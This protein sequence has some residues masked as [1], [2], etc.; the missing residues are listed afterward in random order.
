MTKHAPLIDF[1][2]IMERAVPEPN[3]GC[4]LWMRALTSAGYATIGWK[5]YPHRMIYRLFKGEIPSGLDL[6]H[7]CR[8]RSCVNPDHLEP[9]TRRENLRRGINW[10]REKTHC[11]QGHPYDKENTL[12]GGGSKRRFRV[13]R[14]CRRAYERDLRRRKRAAL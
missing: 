4:W 1:G 14:I 12:Q 5:D 3:S 11:P 2:W 6:D 9:V 7:K 13:C 8:V 10:E